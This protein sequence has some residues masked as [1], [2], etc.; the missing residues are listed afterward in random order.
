[1]PIRGAL[2]T[3]GACEALKQKMDM[4]LTGG[5]EGRES[6]GSL[7]LRRFQGTKMELYRKTWVAELS[8]GKPLSST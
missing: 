7:K 2:E 5:Q 8:I 3:H 6:A 1:M 4:W